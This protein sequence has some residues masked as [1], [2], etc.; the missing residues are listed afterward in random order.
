M[1]IKY[2]II[3]SSKYILVNTYVLKKSEGVSP[4]GYRDN[5]KRPL[6]NIRHAYAQILSKVQLFRE[7]HKNLRNLPRG[8][9]I[10][11]SKP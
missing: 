1:G 6:S 4:A 3:L 11:L 2:L 10:Y 5:F 8:F 7:G 9:D